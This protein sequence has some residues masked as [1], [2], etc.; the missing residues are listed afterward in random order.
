MLSVTVWSGVALAQ[1]SGDGDGGPSITY[2]VDVK[3]HLRD[4]SSLAFA[5]P[6]SVY[7]YAG[8]S[9]TTPSP[10]HSFEISSVALNVDAR[11]APGIRAHGSVHFIDLYARNPTSTGQRAFIREAWLELGRRR[12]GLAPGRR[13]PFYA[14]VGMAPRFSRET[15]R[16]LESFGLWGVAVGWLEQLQLQVGGDIGPFV[17]WR[18]HVANPNPL[19]L[20][21]TN[22]LAGDSAYYEED[23]LGSGFPILYDTRAPEISVRGSWEYGGGLGLRAVSETTRD[24][25]D[26][27]AWIF[28]R[29]LA[30]RVSIPDSAWGG[31]LELLHAAG[32]AVKG[33]TK[34]ERGANLQAR[35]GGLRFFA[36]V[37]DQ[38]IAG[39]RRSGYEVEMAYWAPLPGL[40]AS[41]DTPVVNWIQPAVRFSRINNKF[42]FQ[43]PVDLAAAPS[44]TWDWTKLD[45]GVRVGIVRGIDFTVEAARHDMILTSGRKL[46]PDEGLA[47]LRFSY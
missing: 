9:L 24:G 18:A 35:L 13:A 22:A 47:T 6:T 29:D 5:V 1:D 19:F 27:L 12:N 36:Q 23:G 16:R 3:V 31:D 45:L 11:L 17:Y 14:L 7:P 2:G 41:G 4:S 38:D 44:L 39:L 40:F 21:D 46:H 26:L 34:E 28:R 25:L 20:R 8:A 30:D 43:P 42:G 32:L 37:V 10:G 15:S 33:R